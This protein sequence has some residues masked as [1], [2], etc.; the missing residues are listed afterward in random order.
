M[1]LGSA[2]Y[3]DSILRRRLGMKKKL[4]RNGLVFFLV[5]VAAVFAFC[6]GAGETK[7]ASGQKKFT[8]GFSNFSV[9]N[10]Y[11]VQFTEVLRQ[12]YMKLKQQGVMD[13]LI[14]TNSNLD[15]NKQIADLKD[16]ITQKV[17]A[18]LVS[19]Q[20]PTALNPVLEDAIDKGIVVV[21]F[22]SYPSTD[23]ITCKVVD[24]EVLFGKIDGEWL[25]KALNGKGNIIILSGIAGNDVNDNR[26][27]GA[28][29]EL[30]KYPDI[31]VLGEAYAE[32]DYA[33]GKVA[34]ENMLAAYPQ[35]DGVFS[36]GGAMTQ[37]AI[38]AFIEAGR[39]LVP[40]T[41][42]SNNG[43]L[44]E[45][46]KYMGKDKFDSVGPVTSDSVSATALD[47]AIKALK[48]ESVPKVIKL[49]R[50]VITSQTIDKYLKPNLPDSLV[51]P[52]ILPD[53][54]IKQLFSK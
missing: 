25:G 26:Y 4:F 19:A 13:N 3:E 36:Q 48:G 53:D 43:F 37:G 42:E 41:G 35:I 5:L 8:V 54:I 29:N 46:K 20:S 40:M 11:R 47:T 50:D 16:L 6:G 14:I 34:T 27:H 24:D 22:N 15:I 28:M 32:W 31:K 23:K 45:W 7:T 49:T 9:G 39:P 51:C 2:A 33:K 44:K 52:S 17:D 30:S 18:I 21:A 38:D 12:E 10:T 1:Q